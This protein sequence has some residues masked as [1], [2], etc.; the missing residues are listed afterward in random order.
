MPSQEESRLVDGHSFQVSM[1]PN[2]A[3]LRV[4][5]WVFWQKGQAKARACWVIGFETESL[6]LRFPALSH[7]CLP[8]CWHF[9]HLAAISSSWGPPLRAF[10]V[11]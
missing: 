5:S 3:G 4:E 2:S 1:V 8:R 7:H 10:R 9:H 6:R 11:L